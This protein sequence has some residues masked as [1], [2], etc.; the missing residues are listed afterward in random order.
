MA[1]VA[2]PAGGYVWEDPG[3]SI[4]IQVNFDLVERLGAAVKQGLGTG[5]R[6]VEIGGI[7]IG[8]ALP[9][10]GRT[11]LIEDFELSTCEH[12]RGASYTLS[13]GDRQ[14]LSRR[15]ERRSAR[16]VVG[17]FRS[18]TRPGMYLDQDDFAVFSRYFPEASQV[19]LLVRPEAE[20]PAMG[21]FFFWEDGDMNRRS[22]YRQF[23][24][25][26]ER[27]AA[28]GFPIA[29]VQPVA[30]PAARLKPVAVP[31]VPKPQASKPLREPRAPLRL[32]SLPWLVVPVIAGLFLAA[33][34]FVSENGPAKPDA[35][36]K[37]KVSPPVDKIE[38]L[39]PQ[40]EPQAA[41][42]AVEPAP[43]PPVEAAPVRVPKR[44]PIH[45]PMLT[46]PAAPAAPPTRPIA[47]ALARLHG[48]SPRPRRLPRAA[49]M[50][51]RFRPT[52]FDD[53]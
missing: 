36:V 7:L 50:P 19:F 10:F 20:G 33:G 44:R 21:G 49:S 34:L 9:G 3:D 23:P 15:L 2:S 1:T 35:V 52:Q 40:P 4:I 25:D 38:P 29:G 22:P 51:P 42:P 48:P 8:R 28:G 13:P 43:A 46:P 6:G 14:A 17:Y 41:A 32:P 47:F 37:A 45:K 24:F 30:A 26:S 27:L 39:L 18:H 31:A 53:R 12:L 11:V 5:Q 16:Q